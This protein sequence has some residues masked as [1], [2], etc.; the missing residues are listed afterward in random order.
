MNNCTDGEDEIIGSISPILKSGES[1]D[2]AFGDLLA[3][4]IDADLNST[5]VFKPSGCSSAVTASEAVEALLIECLDTHDLR[6]H[7]ELLANN[8]ELIAQSLEP[9]I[10]STGNTVGYVVPDVQ[11]SFGS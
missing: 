2:L 4:A 3:M 9:V 10:D 8:A 5:S 1:G 7:A 6:A 11:S